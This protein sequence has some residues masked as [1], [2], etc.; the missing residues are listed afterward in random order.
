MCWNDDGNTVI[1]DVDLFQREILSQRG[2][3]RIFETDSLKMF[4]CQLNLHRF[5]KM[6][7]NRRTGE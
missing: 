4:I 6:Y 1:I 3:E 7:P 2:A 5:S